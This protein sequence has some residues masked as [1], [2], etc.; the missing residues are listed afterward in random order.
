MAIR[1]NERSRDSTRNPSSSNILFAVLHGL[2][3]RL[4][5]RPLRELDLA[6][7]PA[8]FMP[9][10]V[11]P[12]LNMKKMRCLFLVLALG[13]GCCSRQVQGQTSAQNMTFSIICQYVTNTFGTN[14]STATTNEDQQ[15]ITVF[16]NS[17]NI[18]RAI[19]IDLEGTNWNR[20]GTNSTNWSGASLVYEQ[21]LLTTNQGIYLRLD[22]RQTNVSSFFGGSLTNYFS[23]EV[24]NVFSGMNFTTLPLH[25]GYDYD[26]RGAKSTNY[27]ASDN[28]AFLTFSSTNM[29]FNL[30]GYSQGT[31]VKV[32]QRFQDQLYTNKVDQAEIVGAGTFSLNVTTNIYPYLNINTYTIP[33]NYTGIAHGTVFTTAPY[34]LDIGPPEG[35]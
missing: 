2:C 21:N 20:G 27:T 32:V 9:N 8:R 5:S 1:V 10:G 34:L 6:R 23:H 16:I 24:N 19:A 13:L 26:V 28:L 35:P 33:T 15:I 3:Q 22:G 30:F 31:L 25:G 12:V 29:S 18:A 17:A 7:E 11:L 14:I 4:E